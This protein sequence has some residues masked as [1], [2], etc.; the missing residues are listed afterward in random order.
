LDRSAADPFGHITPSERERLPA[1]LEAVIRQA[2]TSSVSSGYQ[3]VS[4]LV[5]DLTRYS[6]GLVPT[7]YVP[8]TLVRLGEWLRVR[9]KPLLATAAVIAILAIVVGVTWG[10]Q[11]R[12]LAAW[13]VVIS[14]NFADPTWQQRWIEPP[15]PEGMFSVTDG[16]VV[17]IADRDAF[18]IYRKRLS[19]PVAIE[20]TGEMQVGTLPCDLSVQWSEASGVAEDPSR[21]AQ[22]GRSY[23][24]Q[25]GAFGNSFCAIFQN[26]GR[27]LLALA[28]RQLEV[29]RAYHYRVELDGTRISMDIDGVRVLEHHDVFPTQSGFIS[30]YGFYPGKTFSDVRILQGSPTN[31]PTPLTSGDNDFLERRYGEAAAQYA[32]VAELTKGGALLQQA[33]YRKGL[34]EWSQGATERATSAWDR[35]TDSDLLAQIDCVRLEDVF[36]AGERTPRV[37]RFEEQYR[38]RPDLR[39]RLRQTWIMLAQQQL[40]ASQRD[41]GAIASFLDIRERLFPQDEAGR[42]V[43]AMMLLSLRRYE[44]V[45]A[46]F[47]EQQNPCARAMLALGRTKQL[48]D[49][50]WVGNDERTHALGMRG[51]FAEVLNAPGLFPFSR[52]RTLIH[53]GRAEEALA[54]EGGAHAALLHLGRAAEA[55]DLPNPKGSSINEALIC[56]GRLNEAAGNGLPQVPGSGSDS[57]AML[58]LGQVDLAE[59]AAKKSYPAIRFMQ[60][61]ESGNDQDYVTFHDQIWLPPDLGGLTGWFAPIVLRPFVDILRGDSTALDTQ[62]RPH[63]ELLSGTYA[64]TPWF[65]ARALLGETPLDSVL[66]MPSRDEAVAWHLVTAGIKAELD[67]H[68]DAALRAYAQFKALP[69]HQR[70]L[71]NNLPDAEVEWLVSWRLRALS[72]ETSTKAASP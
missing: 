24:I 63:L 5:H 30:L 67:G 4:D 28:N 17:S 52:I 22:E 8:G 48:L 55:L 39:D 16:K 64:Q 14:E 9:R 26:P 20:F 21:F 19:T 65:V 10:R 51:L 27:T 42:Y 44:E 69:M 56:L 34:A 38:D 6:E 57:T 43:A 2:L 68:R 66:D 25:S 15:S 35:V 32:R 36:K 70:L 12:T 31:G 58:M 50:E 54:L 72:D 45:L 46:N 7:A 40:T 71:V 53:V 60:A 41:A 62:V 49:T 61:A 33:L 1:S 11:L 3:D 37:S 29:G 13:Q 23:M 47:P 18:L 59:L